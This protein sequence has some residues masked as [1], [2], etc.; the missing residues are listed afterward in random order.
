MGLISVLSVKANIPNSI[1]PI[2]SY[3]KH[4]QLNI[5]SM[6]VADEAL[7]H[8]ILAFAMFNRIAFHSSRNV[9]PS[10]STGHDPAILFHKT[11]AMHI[12][13]KKLDSSA[14]SDAMIA[15]TLI[16]QL[17]YVSCSQFL[18]KAKLTGGVAMD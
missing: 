3:T 18:S 12:M 15:T 6:A 17:Q 8:A 9:P 13:N 16:L 4:S 1:H 14:V 11:K 10:P 5:L 7:L 2:K